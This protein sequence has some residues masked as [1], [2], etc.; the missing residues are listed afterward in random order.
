MH[1]DI[2]ET[3]APCTDNQKPSPPQQDQDNKTTKW[4]VWQ[5]SHGSPMLAFSLFFVGERDTGTMRP[6]SS[7]TESEFVALLLAGCLHG[8]QILLKSVQ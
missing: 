1:F 3:P 5:A 2:V 4:E 8:G 6:V 7:F